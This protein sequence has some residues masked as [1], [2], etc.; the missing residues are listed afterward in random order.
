MSFAM[1]RS[2]FFFGTSTWDKA[3]DFAVANG[4]VLVAAAGNGDDDNVGQELPNYNV[5]PAT[6]TPGVITVGALDASDNA[7]T[8]SN[9]GSSISVWAPG[10]NIPVAPDGANPNGSQPSGTS[11][12]SPIVAGVAAMM[13]AVNPALDSVAVRQILVE[14]GW[15]GTGRVSRGLDAQAAVLGALKGTLPKDLSEPNNT[16]ATATELFPVGPGSSA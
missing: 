14:T 1:K 10:N 13:R 11:M 3:F 16:A 15:P 4:V 2:E 8:Y 5:R 7:T 12:A 6:R 9:F